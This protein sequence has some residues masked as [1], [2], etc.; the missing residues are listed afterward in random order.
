M[1]PVP[2]SMNGTGWQ[3]LDCPASFFNVSPQIGRGSIA[4]KRQSRT[5]HG[6][7]TTPGASGTSRHTRHERR[8][9]DL[10]TV[11]YEAG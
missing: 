5:H 8:L 10:R 7:K 4:S 3:R 1:T 11:V 6:N 9:G 2:E